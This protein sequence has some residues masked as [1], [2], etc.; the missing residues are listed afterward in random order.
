MGLLTPTVANT[1]WSLFTSLGEATVSSRRWRG[2]GE[3]SLDEGGIRDAPRRDEAAAHDRL[4]DDYCL[5]GV[6]SASVIPLG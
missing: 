6:R 2:V 1:S 4:Y 5:G 3:D